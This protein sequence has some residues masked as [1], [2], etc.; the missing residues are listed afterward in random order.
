MTVDIGDGRVDT[1]KVHEDDDFEELAR[2]F[3]QKHDL[4]PTIIAP[5]TEHIRI[6]VEALNRKKKKKATKKPQKR[7][8]SA[9]KTY[10]EYLKV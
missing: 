1:I 7:Y 6:T 5:V 9:S 3:Q 2:A 8:H 4:S 10:D